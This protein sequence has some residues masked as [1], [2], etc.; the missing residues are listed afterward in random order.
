MYT[1]TFAALVDR[2]YFF[3]SHLHSGFSRGFIAAKA[4]DSGH[5]G[6]SGSGTRTL[7]FGCGVSINIMLICLFSL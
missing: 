5:L 1:Y 6:V 3:S 2:F 4:S 7:H